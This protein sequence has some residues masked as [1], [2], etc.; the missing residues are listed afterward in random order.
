MNKWLL[1]GV[2]A[3]GLATSQVQAAPLTLTLTQGANTVTVVDGVGSDAALDDM[4]NF[5]GAL[6]TF[7]I[8]VS[9]ALAAPGAQSFPSLMDL[10]SINVGIGNLVIEATKT[11]AGLPAIND[12]LATIGGTLGSSGSASLL[13]EILIDGVEVTEI[14]AAGSNAAPFSDSDFA[15][16]AEDG[17]YDLTLRIT[18]NHTGSGF[19]TTSFDAA[20][21]T[22]VPEPAALALFGAGLLGL[23]V[24]R[25][26]K[27]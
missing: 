25:R 11:F 23:G 9:T 12:L 2:G 8:N 10:N 17:E 14:A 1:L 13:Y 24:V 4:V 22:V 27:A 6:G 19:I 15:A 20:A 3:L 18:L 26:R 7:N 16:F 21:Q 5:N